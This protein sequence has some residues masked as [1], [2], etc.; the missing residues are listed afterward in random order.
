[1]ADRAPLAGWVEIAF[2]RENF[3]QLESSP[4]GL[5]AWDSGVWRAKVLTRDGGAG[6][7]P[8]RRTAQLAAEDTARAMVADMA[9]ALGGRVTWNESEGNG[10]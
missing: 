5:L 9:A 8:T 7:A 2:P 4:L 10:G 3:V 6:V 1:M